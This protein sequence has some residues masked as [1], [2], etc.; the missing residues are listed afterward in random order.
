MFG[1]V[2]GYSGDSDGAGGDNVYQISGS[3]TGGAILHAVL[4][5]KATS[6]RR[7]RRRPFWIPI[8]IFAVLFFLVF[9]LFVVDVAEAKHQPLGL[10]LGGEAE[11]PLFL[12]GGSGWFRPICHSE[13]LYVGEVGW[14]IN[15]NEKVK[16]HSEIEM[17]STAG[18]MMMLGMRNEMN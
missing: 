4:K 6:Q 15:Q 16:I 13:W 9:L 11:P 17:I 5:P 10:R 2:G 18:E 7:K 12:V 8:L 3:S 1:F 14:Q